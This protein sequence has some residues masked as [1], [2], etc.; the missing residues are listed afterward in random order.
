MWNIFKILISKPLVLHIL[1]TRSVR[2]ESRSQYVFS[3]PGNFNMLENNNNYNNNNIIIIINQLSK[4]QWPLDELSSERLCWLLITLSTLETL[5][6]NFIISLPDII[7]WYHWVGVYYIY[8]RLGTTHSHWYNPIIIWVYN[9][10]IHFIDVDIK[11][12][13]IKDI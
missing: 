7:V 6:L 8:A 9:N 1:K 4:A 11:A 3:L 2:V 5:G 12:W 13:K 10:Q